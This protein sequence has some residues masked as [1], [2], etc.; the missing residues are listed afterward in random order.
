[1]KTH[2]QRLLPDQ[3]LKKTLI[4]TIQKN[5]ISAACVLS[6][7]GSLQ[8]AQLRFANQK[9][10]TTLQGPLEILS[11][12]GTLS[13]EGV[14]LHLSVADENGHCWGGHLM[15][16]CLI[17]TTC[18]L[19]LA[20]LKDFQFQRELDSQTGYKELVIQNTQHQPLKPLK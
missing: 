1:M 11:L 15:E 5:N 10:S 19:V 7:V 2:V 13:P 18:E 9:K 16:G 20:E 14:H 8:I 6:A 3:D 12:Q 17:F 4:D